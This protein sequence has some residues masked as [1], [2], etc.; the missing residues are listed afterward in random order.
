MTLFERIER[1]WTSAKAAPARTR[2][3]LPISPDRVENS[4]SVGMPFA[5]GEHYFQVW[6]NELFLQHGRQWFVQFD[7]MSFVATRYLYDKEKTTAAFVVGPKMLEGI[8]AADVPEGMIFRN[9]PVSGMHPYQGGEV[10][11]TILLSRVPREDGAAN[12]LGILESVSTAIDPSTVFSSYVKLGQTLLDGVE[13]VLGINGTQPVLG[14]RVAVNPTVGVAFEP[15]FHALL[16]VD[17]NEIDPDNFFVRDARLHE[18]VDGE[19]KPYRGS[20]FLLFSVRQ[21]TKREDE[22][23]LPF[24]P[25]WQTTQDLAAQPGDHF[26]E[27]AKHNFNALKRAMLISPDLTKPDYKRLRE[28]WLSELTDRRQE[29]VM[30][31][32]LGE[33]ELEGEEVELADVARRLDSVE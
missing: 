6:V 11:F 21:A 7:P 10:E 3:H 8:E 28:E 32:E 18:R 33:G 19:L 14:Y 2:A 12:L 30:D 4:G 17:E 29:A 5:K 20:D 22:R 9:T 13:S 15:G 16:D 24:F 26:W 25:L 31:S 23:L 27:E 1:L